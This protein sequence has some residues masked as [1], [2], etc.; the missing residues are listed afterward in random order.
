M[1]IINHQT[2]PSNADR[3]TNHLLDEYNS[4][5]SDVWDCIGRFAY[6]EEMWTWVT[7]RY[8]DVSDFVFPIDVD[9]YIAVLPSSTSSLSVPTNTTSETLSWSKEHLS[10]ALQKL[11]DTGKPFKIEMGNVYPVD[12][13]NPH[14]EGEASISGTLNQLNNP[15][16]NQNHYERSIFEKLQYVARKKHNRANCMDKVFFRG[17]DFVRTDTGNHH[18]ETHSQSIFFSRRRCRALVQTGDGKKKKYVQD[19]DQASDLFMVHVQFTTMEEW[20]M[21]ALRGASD[22]GF[23]RFSG[24][25]KCTKAMTSREYC[26]QWKMLM[27]TKFDPREIKRVYAEKVC[28][29]VEDKT[30]PVPI[31]QILNVSK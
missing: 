25:Q 3:E 27:D 28:T 18:G 31:A 26:E 13:R 2:S 24:L 17:K 15:V 20:M 21:H 23:N 22:R 7:R 12:C 11:K 8:T 1:V 4:R 6:K 19:P 9:E 14:W 30:I 5:G 16:Q 10:K 29:L